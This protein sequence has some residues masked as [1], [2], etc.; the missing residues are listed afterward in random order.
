VPGA[1][2]SPARTTGRHRAAAPGT[3][4]VSV[5]TVLVAVDYADRNALGA[6]APELKDDLGLS[7]ADL[8]YLGA[9]FGVVGGVAT[10]AAGALIDRVP[11]LRLLAGS[12]LAWSVAMLACGVA[13]GLLWLLV[14]RGALA[15]VLAT[16]G[17]AYPS[18]IGDGVPAARRTR[19]LGS[20]AVGQ[21]L[22]GVLGIALG[23]ACVALLSWRWAFLLL[24]V[25]G[26]LLV[27]SLLRM[28]EPERQG[29]EADRLVG[30][31]AVLRRLLHTPTAVLVILS[32][33]VGSYYLAGA[34]AFSTLFAVEHYDVSTPVADL[35][36]LAL[37]LGAVGGIVV[38]SRMSDALSTSGRGSVRLSRAA[39]A[40][41]LTALL[42]LPALFVTSLAVALPFLVLGSAAL[43]ATIPTLDA[44]RIDVVPPGLRGRTEAVRTLV[45]AVAEGGAPLV[46]G[47]ITQAVGDDDRGLQL[48]FLVALP[49]LVAAAVLLRVA[50]SRYDA[51]RA[52]VVATDRA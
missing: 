15:V 24:A 7:V 35:A 8:G 40:Y 45:R 28:S 14:A 51:D 42:W 2:R 25:P 38:G 16:V 4:L 49:T 50:V 21:L 20:I 9:S 43:A 36:L 3:G 26:V 11:R 22:G 34:S 52:R 33:S 41:V 39:L 1:V 30:L 10:L 13:N 46:F 19:A 32:A 27:G 18:L 29:H 31:E 6:V 44:V 17:P 47:L 23:A 12:A 37:A 5:L 48:S